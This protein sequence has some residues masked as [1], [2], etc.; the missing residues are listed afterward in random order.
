M[1]LSLDGLRPDPVWTD[2][3]E[4]VSH[5]IERVAGDG[6]L[7]TYHV[8]STAIED[9]AGKPALDVIALYADREA[10]SAAAAALSDHEDFE[11]THDGD[12]SA[13]VVRWVET[14]EGTE[15]DFLKLHLPGD[16][17][18]HNQLVFR[19]YVSEHPDARRRYERVKREAAENHPEGR[20][21]YTEHKREVV[22][23][24]LDDARAAGY[25]EDL[26]AVVRD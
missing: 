18:V 5:R 22:S 21:E 2:R 17:R 24:I 12:D 1:A 9:V 13:V 11:L 15:A 19:E 25:V 14:D 6:L 26:P 3:Y 16:E 20:G 4:R 23:E 7:D 8:G 10:L